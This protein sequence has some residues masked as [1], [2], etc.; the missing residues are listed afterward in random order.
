MP[1]GSVIADVAIDA[2]R[3]Q[4]FAC[5]VFYGSGHI[6]INIFVPIEKE[7]FQNYC[8]LVDILN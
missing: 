4:H 8:A 2:R 3:S 7:F 1:C 5:A 6:C